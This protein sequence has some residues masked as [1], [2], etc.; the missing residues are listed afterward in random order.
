MCHTLDVPDALHIV[1]SVPD[2]WLERFRAVAETC[3]GRALSEAR[4]TQAVEQ[5]SRRYTR[6]RRALRHH[7]TDRDELHARL[8]F[9][10]PRDLPKIIAPLNEL[11]AVAA[12]PSGPRW[13]VLDV[14]AGVG[15]TSLGTAWMAR[16]SATAER[17]EVDALD[18]DPRVLSAFRRLAE[19]A[20]KL[21]CVPMAVRGHVSDV[22]GSPPAPQ[23]QGPYQLILV[24]LTL[25]ELWGDA[26][27][28]DASAAAQG[29]RWLEALAGRL[30]EDGVLI[31]LEPALRETSRR[32]H[33]VRDVLA[34]R[35]GPPHIFAPCLHSGTCPM[36]ERDRD[37]CHEQLPARLPPSLVPLA[38]QAGLRIEGLSYSYLT[39][40]RRK[41]D[42]RMLEGGELAHRVVSRPLHSKG[43]LELLTCSEAGSLRVQRLR[44]HA[45]DGNADLERCDRG[46][47]A[48]F[49]GQ[50]DA[51]GRLRVGAEDTVE[52]LLAATAE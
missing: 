49:E 2:A 30:S 29:A 27:E 23:L 24:G 41:G 5:L 32:L 13:R 9:F 14:G 28:D 4:L 21:G 42:L 33:R 3:A 36:L 39:L 6:E 34:S 38:R 12:L 45:R 52:R 43:K 44:R 16:R 48:R 22:A 37:W 46:C 15:T 11:H 26:P 19:D 18:R 17:V 20:S 51:R 31:V 10:L 7:L 25:N 40:R 1:P 35:E 8:R 50:Q 47:V